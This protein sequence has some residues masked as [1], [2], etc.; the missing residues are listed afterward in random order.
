MTTITVT[1]AQAA[2]LLAKLTARDTAAR[3]AQTTLDALTVGQVPESAQLSNIDTATGV[4]TFTVI[5]DG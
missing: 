3:D 2:L 5:A 1:P 4:L